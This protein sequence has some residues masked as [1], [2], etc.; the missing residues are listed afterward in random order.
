MTLSRFIDSVEG[1]RFPMAGILPFGTRML[2]RRKVL[3]YTEAVLRKDCLLGNRGTI[4]RGHE[5]HYSEI[6]E[7]Q[8]TAEIDFAYD[9]RKRKHE[10]PRPEGYVMGSVLASYIHLHWGSAPRAA[11]A[12]VDRCAEWNERG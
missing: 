4:I 2:A 3:G 6:A 10:A 9:L 7:F 5:F 1:R 11:Y 8:E 12:F